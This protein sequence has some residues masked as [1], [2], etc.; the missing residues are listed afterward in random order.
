M[1]EE[2]RK[3]LCITVAAT[4]TL[5]G[6][7]TARLQATG[8]PPTKYA[9]LDCEQLDAEAQKVLARYVELGGKIDEASGGDTALVVLQMAVTGF[10]PLLLFLLPFSSSLRGWSEERSHQ[11]AEYRR[12][13]GERNAILQVAAEK[14]CPGVAQQPKTDGEPKTIP[15]ATK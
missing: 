15:D 14:G 13:L 12:L 10:P 4:M 9:E 11:N 6:C 3:A 5:A 7:G 1:R 8:V 2:F